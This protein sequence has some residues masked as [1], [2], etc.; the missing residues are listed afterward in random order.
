MAESVGGSPVF[1]RADVP[2]EYVQY[3]MDI[4][5]KL[6]AYLLDHPLP[7]SF[8]SIFACSA[9]CYL[10][11]S[12]WGFGHQLG[13]ILECPTAEEQALVSSSHQL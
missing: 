6:Y 7:E 9:S 8:A 3:Q 1:E 12:F 2:I 4:V 13:Q 11:L 5:H 10:C